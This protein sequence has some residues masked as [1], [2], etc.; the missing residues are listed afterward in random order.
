MH[1]IIIFALKNGLKLTKE[2]NEY[3]GKLEVSKGEVVML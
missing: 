3:V 1:I 2:Q